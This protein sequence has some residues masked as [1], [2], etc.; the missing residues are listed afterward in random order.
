MSPLTPLLITPGR[1]EF[2]E[3]RSRQHWARLSRVVRWRSPDPLNGS[4]RAEGVR[5]RSVRPPR[6]SAS[7]RSLSGTPRCRLGF[8]RSA[9]GPVQAYRPIP[10][11]GPLGLPGPTDRL[12]DRFGQPIASPPLTPALPGAN[13][14]VAIRRFACAKAMFGD[15]IQ[16]F[17]AIGDR[18]RRAV[19]DPYGHQTQARRGFRRRKVA[20]GSAEYEPHNEG[21]VANPVF[22]VAIRKA[23]G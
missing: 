8:H 3:S 5:Q 13:V 1:A 10:A 2:T 9:L 19:W 20:A 14:L 18:P 16:M 12:A 6:A 11:L 17:G 22:P 4:R 7:S 15:P 21:F 23:G